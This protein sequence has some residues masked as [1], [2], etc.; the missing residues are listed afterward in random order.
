MKLAPTNIYHAQLPIV[1]RRVASRSRGKMKES[2]RYKLFKFDEVGRYES[3]S[4]FNYQQL[5]TTP[6]V[7]QP[8]L[9]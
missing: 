7:M 4:D 3:P 2:T 6:K 1:G 9:Q 8:L 5:S